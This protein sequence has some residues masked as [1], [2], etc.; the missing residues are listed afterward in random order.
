MRPQVLRI[1]VAVCI[2]GCLL[3]VGLTMLE[4][5]T[6]AQGGVLYVAPGGDCGD[7]EPCYAHPQ[8]AV[9]AASQGDTIKVAAGTYAGV[10]ARPVPSGYPNP[11]S[12]GLITQVVYPPVRARLICF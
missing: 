9:D 10:S 1:G 6:Q 7:E 8:D 3:F 4:R 12:S 11:P 2:A 5:Q